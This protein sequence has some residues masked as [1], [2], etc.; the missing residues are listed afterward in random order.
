MPGKLPAGSRSCNYLDDD[1]LPLCW[2]DEHEELLQSRAERRFQGV[3][4]YGVVYLP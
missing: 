4:S 1:Q 2:G 3:R